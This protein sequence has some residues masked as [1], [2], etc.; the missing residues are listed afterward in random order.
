MMLSEVALGKSKELYNAE[1]VERLE[2]QYHSVKGVGRKGPGY[3]HTLVLP[4]GV[5]IP[6]GKVEDYYS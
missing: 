5:K 4:N 1:Y 6:Y 2:P 3:D